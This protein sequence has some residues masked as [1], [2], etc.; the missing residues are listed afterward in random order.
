MCKGGVKLPHFNLDYITKAPFFQFGI[1]YASKR[2]TVLSLLLVDIRLSGVATGNSRPPENVKITLNF[3]DERPN[4][5][6]GL[7]SLS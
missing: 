6:P 5:K 3:A 7:F 1:L 2:I 4:M